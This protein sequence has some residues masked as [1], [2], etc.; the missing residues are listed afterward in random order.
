[1]NENPTAEVL[2]ETEA[3]E[4]TSAELSGEQTADAESSAAAAEAQGDGEAA[5]PAEQSEA[6]E[7][8]PESP[9]V[10]AKFN[11]QERVYSIEEAAPLV[12]QGLKYEQI[13]PEFEKLRYLAHSMDTD[14]P[15]L[16]GRLMG[17]RDEMML[18][19]AV[20]ECG[21]NEAAGKKLFELQK[22]ERDR[23]FEELRQTEAKAAEE[24]EKTERE[25]LTKRLADDF[26]ELDR[27]M[28]GE[29]KDFSAVPQEVVNLAVRRGI[30]LLDAYLRVQRS[31]SRKIEA[32]KAQQE[33]A[34]KASIGSVADT[35]KETDSNIESFEA[36]F[37]RSVYR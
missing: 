19:Q 13:K 20:E 14:V 18:K 24:E 4:N 31:E 22:A 29:F 34:A 3:E 8:K 12:E 36:A 27:E 7:E 9:V 26:I 35:P 21:G 15:G 37:R 28:P 16:I 30:P 1:M 33:K 32:A 5:M 6:E 23:K 25:Q 2:Q 17:S 11:K 10:R